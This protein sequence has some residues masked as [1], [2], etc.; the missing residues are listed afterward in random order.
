MSKKHVKEMIDQR[1]IDLH[2]EVRQHPEL[3]EILSDLN[4][5]GI[6]ASEFEVRLAAIASYCGVILDGEYLQEELSALC[7]ILTDK[8]RAKR[9]VIIS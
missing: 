3:I 4:Q 1:R 6:D 8:L 9:V 5:Q 2:L 7:P